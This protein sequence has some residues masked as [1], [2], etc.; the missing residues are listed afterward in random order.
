MVSPSYTQSHDTHASNVSNLS[1]HSNTAEEQKYDYSI[2]EDIEAPLL[3]QKKSYEDDVLLMHLLTPQCPDSDHDD[4]DNDDENC[5]VQRFTYHPQQICDKFQSDAPLSAK[6]DSMR[7]SPSTTTIVGDDKDFDDYYTMSPMPSPP[8]PAE[9]PKPG[10]LVHFSELH[11]QYSLEE[12]SFL[13]RS[14][15]L[16][17]DTSFMEELIHSMNQ[18][19]LKPTKYVISNCD[20]RRQ[21]DGIND[22]DIFVETIETDESKMSIV[23]FLESFDIDQVEHTMIYDYFIDH[24][25]VSDAMDLSRISPAEILSIC[26]QLD[27]ESVHCSI[28]KLLNFVSYQILSG[29]WTSCEYDAWAEY[30]SNCKSL[31]LVNNTSNE[32]NGSD[33]SSGLSVQSSQSSLESSN[34]ANVTVLRPTIN[35]KQYALFSNDLGDALSN[36]IAIDGAWTEF[37]NKDIQIDRTFGVVLRIKPNNSGCHSTDMQDSAVSFIVGVDFIHVNNTLYVDNNLNVYGNNTF[38]ETLTSCAESD[39]STDEL[40][41][42]VFVNNRDKAPIISFRAN[43][44]DFVDFDVEHT[45]KNTIAQIYIQQYV[46]SWTYEI[47]QIF[48]QMPQSQSG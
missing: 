8:A 19:Q 30:E 13:E 23:E 16:E 31:T 29:F 21:C 33:S 22:N 4:D 27:D 6:L 5:S 11:Q 12:R 45:V 18:D 43:H 28:A 1:Q 47:V 10:S 9:I 48:E 37:I 40:Q 46:G 39:Q 15:S 3:K 36:V 32:S 35:S 38:I 24:L 7:L 14:L 42:T 26:E 34:S 20:D 25:N 41:L 44:H 17:D 2:D